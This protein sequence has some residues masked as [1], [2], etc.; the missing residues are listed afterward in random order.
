VISVSF[1]LSG[2]GLERK[3]NG[4]VRRNEPVVI[5]DGTNDREAVMAYPDGAR[6]TSTR[7]PRRFASV[8]VVRSPACTMNG[9]DNSE[10][11]AVAMARRAPALRHP[12]DVSPPTWTPS[13]MRSLIAWS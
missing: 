7:T 12:S 5:R 3:R 1:R 9:R 10:S 13:S 2:F 4:D 6:L 11:V 8:G